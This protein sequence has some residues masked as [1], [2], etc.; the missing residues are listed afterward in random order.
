MAET[1]VTSLEDD[2]PVARREKP[3][4]G[5][6][7]VPADEAEAWN[8]RARPKPPLPGFMPPTEAGELPFRP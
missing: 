7:R 3:R 6:Y 5:L 4:R 8:L 1:R 2:A